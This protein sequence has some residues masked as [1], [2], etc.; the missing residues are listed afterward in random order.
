[1]RFEPNIPFSSQR[2]TVVVDAGLPAGSHR[3]RLVVFNE[4]GQQSSPVEFTVRVLPRLNGPINPEP[5]EPIVVE[6][7]PVRPGPIS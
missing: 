6:P 1:M 4:N 3:F 2:P 7:I 5:F